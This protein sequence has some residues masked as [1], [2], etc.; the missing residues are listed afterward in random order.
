MRR[1]LTSAAALAATLLLPLAAHT[2]L[3]QVSTVASAASARVIVKYRA[4]SELTKKQALGAN[5]K[6][7]MQAQALGARIGVALT[8]G[9]ALSDRTH[10]V[11]A[12]GMDSASLAARIAAEK[13]VEYA[14]PDERKHI[15][16]APNDPLYTTR[17]VAGSASAP[18]GGPAVG[19][20]YLK[21]PGAA[22]TAAGTAPSAINAQQA[23]D[24]TLGSA[25]I[26]VAVLD[27]GVR[28]DHP[29]LQ[30]GNVLPG[31]DMIDAD[32]PPADTDFSTANDGNGRDSDASDP[33]DWVSA[34]DIATNPVFTKCTQSDT[35]SWHG[36]ET[37]GLIGAATD[38]GT[39]IASV[40]HGV[41]KVMPVRVLGKCGGYD[42]DIIAGIQWAA[43]I[44]VPGVPDNAIANRARVINM[45]LGGG[46]SC[47]QAYIDAV[48]QA[49][50]V[51]TVVVASAGN[52]AGHAVGSPANCPGVLAVTGL[53]HVGTK[54]GFSDLGPGITIS[55]PGGNCIN[56]TKNSEC[57]YPIMSL[58][59]SGV[60]TPVLGAVGGT[61]TDSFVAPS[62]GT[63][64]S[65]P[66]VAGT[67]AL[68]LSAK[69]AMTPL[70]VRYA[71]QASAQPFPTTGGT[72]MVPVCVDPS[73]LPA[74]TDQFECY[75]PNPSATVA[76]VCGTGMLNAFSA[77]TQALGVVARISVATVT[78]TALQP[79]TINSSSLISA[80]QSAT[81]VWTIVSAGSTGATIPAGTATSPSIVVTPT[82]AGTFTVNLTTTDN[83]GIVSAAASA[84]TVASAAV[85]TPPSGG[86]SSGGGALG[87]GWLALLLGAV[88]A[89]AVASRH[90]RRRRAVSVARVARRR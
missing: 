89:L 79:V 63:S 2:P 72:A 26:V 48:A 58:S 32:N 77:V 4:E 35:S 57:L 55:A 74:N 41:V 54:V 85:V 86:G 19:Q 88:L 27:T 31:Y 3:A 25:S 17:P 22:R 11:F 15:V 28:F 14:V 68:M 60:T 65:S 9:R 73:T 76:S 66:L 6:P 33:G 23:W 50:A 30:G 62:L 13:D 69:P 18:S 61:Y 75:C 87:A 80:G 59:N 53:R 56:T 84:I 36:T 10:V 52:S 82:A 5:P 64:F 51:G 46:S 20:W 29:D 49:N 43:G 16:A 34:N 8:A 78:P 21:P 44:H 67:V 90:K 7:M 39:G 71:L 37:L 47:S 38:N 70:E 45:S 24:L 83:N 42:S 81:Y 12:Q 1:V 40:G